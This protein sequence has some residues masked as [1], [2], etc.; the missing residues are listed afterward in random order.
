MDLFAL[1]SCGDW[2]SS[3]IVDSWLS[4]V[5]D[6]VIPGR[7]LSG[8]PSVESAVE[9]LRL[10]ALD[11][12]IKPFEAAALCRRVA[13]IRSKR[14]ENPSRP[15]KTALRASGGEPGSKLAEA[16]RLLG[17][18]ATV[19]ADDATRTSAT[20]HSAPK[21]R[22]SSSDF[23]TRLE[24]NSNVLLRLSAR[25]RQVVQQLLRCG[26]VVAVS[27]ALNISHHTVRNHLRSIFVKVGVRSQ[28]DL[29]L[30]ATRGHNTAP[31]IDLHDL[32]RPNT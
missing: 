20:N 24:L 23:S 4:S 10:R 11:Y 12:I 30:A 15:F 28:V 32:S 8:S 17:I 13:E 9:A 18:L 29:V 16:R 31:G 14:S 7:G 6:Q 22:P 19:L 26:S 3:P 1:G 27:D 2:A 5:H 21:T 25:E